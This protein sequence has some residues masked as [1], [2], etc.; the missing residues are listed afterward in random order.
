MKYTLL[1]LVMMAGFAFCA[2]QS[3]SASSG[4]SNAWDNVMNN[5]YTKSLYYGNG[6]SAKTTVA[7]I[8]TQGPASLTEI[9][10]AQMNTKLPD[11]RAALSLQ[12]TPTAVTLRR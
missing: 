12:R 8:K 1:S 4:N 5:V 10:K 9:N 3:P 6:V 7:M 2:D 11:F